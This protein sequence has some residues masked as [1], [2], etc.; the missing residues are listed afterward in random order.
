MTTT[1]II[2]RHGNTFLP[3]ETPT[4]VGA[5]TDLPLVEEHRGRSIGKYLKENHMVPD[6]IFCGPLK[7]QIQTAELVIEEMGVKLKININESFRE[8]DYGPDENKTDKEI[9]ER[10]GQEALKSWDAEG[11]LPKGW[12]FDKEQ[13]INSW[14]TF[15][16]KI[17]KE[18]KNKTI[19]VVSSGG[20]I[21]FAP[22]LTG[23]FEQ[24][25]KEHD[26]KIATGG[27]CLFT[28]EEKETHWKCR[29]WGVKPYKIYS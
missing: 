17:E 21:R 26:I 4:R 20:T 10:I 25:S 5:R 27:I 15:A 9:I 3:G 14:K 2:A 6:V 29:E 28:K 12:T 8:V 13:L 22:H 16:N 24:F 1:L 18:Y 11:V 7:R 19:L 23:N